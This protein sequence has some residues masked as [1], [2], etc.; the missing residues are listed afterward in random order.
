MIHPYKIR[1]ANGK[2]LDTILDLINNQSN[3]GKILKRTRKDVRKALRQ[4]FRG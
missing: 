1:E 4:F 2:D 3:N